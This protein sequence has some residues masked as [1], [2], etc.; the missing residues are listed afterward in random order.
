VHTEDHPL[1]Y[2]DFHGEIPKGE[3]GGGSMTI[4]DEGTYETLKWEERK[5]EVELRGSAGLADGTYAL[6]HTGPTPR[7]G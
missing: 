5:I 2:I 7:T 6:F 3:Y 1:E 4:W